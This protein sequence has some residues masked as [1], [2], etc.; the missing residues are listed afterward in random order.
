MDYFK[1]KTEVKK[2]IFECGN[3]YRNIEGEKM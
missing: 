3:N 1:K 2:L